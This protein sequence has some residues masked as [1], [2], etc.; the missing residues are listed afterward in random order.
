MIYEPENGVTLG[1]VEKLNSQHYIHNFGKPS[2]SKLAIELEWKLHK[3]ESESKM[4]VPLVRGSPYTSVKYLNITPRI[5][6]E[7]PLLGNIIVDEGYVESKILNCGYGLNN[8][9]LEPVL[10]R[11]EMKFNLD[12]SDQ[13]WNVFVSEPTYFICST[14]PFEDQT[15]FENQYLDIKSV[16]P[17]KRGMVRLAMTNNCTTGKNPQCK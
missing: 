3:N 12:I 17:M 5:Y 11:H 4:Q 14:I 6:A 2:I 13:T 15:N 16:N 8:F 9:T 10:V 7:R 1:S